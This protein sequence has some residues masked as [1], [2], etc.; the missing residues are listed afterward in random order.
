MRVLSFLVASGASAA[1]LAWS[2]VAGAQV[3][4]AERAA[5]REL[6]KQG[7]ELQRAGRFAEALDKFERAQQVFG[8]PTNQLRIAECDAALGRLVESAEAYRAVVR[9]ALPAGSPPA[10]Q[11]AVDQAKAEL[12]QI[13]PRIPRLTIQVQPTVDRAE[14]QIDGQTVPSALIGEPMPLD[15][16]RHQ[17]AV[18]APGYAP[19]EQVIELKEREIQ[20]VSFVLRSMPTAPLPLP[21]PPVPASAPPPPAPP[22]TGAAP[23]PRSVAVER[24]AVSRLGLLL[25]GHLGGEILSGSVP[26]GDGRSVNADAIG[27]AGFAFGADAGL[28]FARHWFVGGVVEH[29]SLGQGNRSELGP[30]VV[31][32]SNTTLAG[33]TFGF[34]GNPDW[35]SFYGEVGVANR[36]LHYRATCPAVAGTSFCGPV[37]PADYTDSSAELTLGAGVWIPGGRSFRLLPKA[38]LGLG[39]FNQP[40]PDSGAATATSAPWH[41]FFMIGIAGFYNLDF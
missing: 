13:E 39:A 9:T 31:V 16:G 8:A 26:V 24:P 15:P 10:F 22:Y 6:F 41:T 5:A 38:T 34:I 18:T 2:G 35:T 1:A 14:L 28:R 25:G 21:P 32:S 37:A 27:S 17:V 7:D 3:S 19:A 23:A 4:D 33:V 20:P 40:E 11:A 29:A 30:G 12:G 36:W